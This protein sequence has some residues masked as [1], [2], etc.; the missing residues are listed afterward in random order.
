MTLLE[1]LTANPE[2]GIFILVSGVLVLGQ[3]VACIFAKKTWVRW[4]PFGASLLLMALCFVL[5]GLSGWTNWGFLILIALV[6]GI[7]AAQGM[8]LLVAWLIR[9][10]LKK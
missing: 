8:T 1:Y 4:L 2:D 6:L 10:I 5:Y 9:K 3:V 7:M